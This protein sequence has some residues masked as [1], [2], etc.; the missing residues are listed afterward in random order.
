GTKDPR[1]AR[2]FASCT[3]GCRNT[4]SS[5]WHRQHSK[6]SSQK[7]VAPCEH[8]L[9]Q[10]GGYRK[11]A[12]CASF[13]YGAARTRGVTQQTRAESSA[14]DCGRVVSGAR[15]GVGRAGISRPDRLLG[16]ATGWSF[17]RPSRTSL[18]CG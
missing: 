1:S 11:P 15:F 5:R 13:T 14:C 10:V 9:K 17:V 12:R 18:D 7:R 4:P 6:L 8:S 3:E 2:T 16:S